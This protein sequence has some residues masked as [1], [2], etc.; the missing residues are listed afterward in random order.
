MTI[1]YFWL[2]KSQGGCWAKGAAKTHVLS[3][4]L[5]EIESR[6]SGLGLVALLLVIALV[7]YDG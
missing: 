3:V 2:F 4:H 5:S 6:V 1:S 7:N